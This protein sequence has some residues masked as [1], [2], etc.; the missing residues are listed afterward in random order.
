MIWF[1]PSQLLLLYQLTV[2][3]SQVTLGIVCWPFLRTHLWVSQKVLSQPL[4][5]HSPFQEIWLGLLFYN[6]LQIHLS[7]LFSTS[8]CCQSPLSWQ[9]ALLEGILARLLNPVT[10]H[11]AICSGEV[12]IF[13]LDQILEV[14]ATLF[15][16]S[17]FS[18]SLLRNAKGQKDKFSGR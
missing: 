18:F 5:L 7:V 14:Q 17:E 4:S 15:G 8:T 3:W 6:L 9:G 2:I 12:C 10:F 13:L 16:L 1:L 11:S